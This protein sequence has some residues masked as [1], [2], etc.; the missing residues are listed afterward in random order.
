MKSNVSAQ[1]RK[2]IQE[3][4]KWAKQYPVK[5]AEQNSVLIDLVIFLVEYQYY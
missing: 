2:L 5:T 3:I 1:E 4:Y